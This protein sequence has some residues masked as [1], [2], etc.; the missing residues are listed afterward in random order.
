[1]LEFLENHFLSQLVF[2]PMHGNNIIDLV[3]VSQDHLINNV[4]VGEH[5]GSCDHK[6]VR[7]D[8][9]TIIHVTLM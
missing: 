2:E 6:L 4:V 5:L 1:M 7:A 3:I 9:N 8:I